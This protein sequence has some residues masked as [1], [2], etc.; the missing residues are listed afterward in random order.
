MLVLAVFAVRATPALT[1]VSILLGV[2]VVV[3]TIA[4][5]I[6]PG[7]QPVVLW[8]A[9][10]HGAFYLYI[11]YGLIAYMFADR[12]ITTDELF[13]IGATFTVVAWAFAYFY[14]GIQ[15]I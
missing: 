2:P 1:W 15:I 10:L 3:L 13:A 14:M 6:D 9:I 8:S 12:R 4:E 7:N 11:S 5:G